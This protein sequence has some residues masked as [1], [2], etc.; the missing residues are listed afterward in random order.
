LSEFECCIRSKCLVEKREDDLSA[1]EAKRHPEQFMPS[2]IERTEL[3]IRIELAGGP[4]IRYDKSL[5]SH[6]SPLKPID[7]VRGQVRALFE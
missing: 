5:L 6:Q 4:Q 7:L 2:W 3:N 1:P